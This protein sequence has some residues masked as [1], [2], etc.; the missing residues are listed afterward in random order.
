MLDYGQF[1][2]ISKAMEVLGERWTMLIVRELLMGSSRFSQLQRG[3]SKIS[4]TVLNT[5]LDML[6]K[7]GLIIK[8]RIP[9]QRGSEYYLTEAGRELFPIVFQIG[10]WGMRWARGQM[11]DEELDVELLMTDIQRKV[12]PEKLPDGQ[13]V[14]HFIFTDLNDYGKWWLKVHG[15]EVD[16]CIDSPGSDVDVH[17]SSDLRTMTE[18]WMGDVSIKQA[19]DEGRL[20]VVGPSAYLRD[21]KS[22]LGLSAFADMPISERAQG[23]NSN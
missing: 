16:L 1:C 14:V 19:R 23:V 7:H 6:R 17:I 4:P 3:L 15:K 18:V 10:E 13:T 22:W 12:N 9:E 21:I 5:R 8:K 20:K 2:P 11:T